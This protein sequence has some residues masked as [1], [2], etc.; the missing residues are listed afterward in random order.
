M[1]SQ[2][3]RKFRQ[4]VYLAQTLEVAKGITATGVLT[5]SSNV[6]VTGTLSVT[7][8]FTARAQANFQA[9]VDIDSVIQ[10]PMTIAITTAVSQYYGLV[11]GSTAFTV[12]VPVTDTAIQP[13]GILQNT[14]N[15]LAQVNMAIGGISSAISKGDG[16]EILVGDK[17]TLNALGQVIKAGTIEDCIGY[18]LQGS[19]T[20][21]LSIKIIV[22]PFNQGIA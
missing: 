7:G 1:A 15:Q 3:I 19:K 11:L 10:T 16:T 17:L 5:A 12:A 14:G 6:G 2:A 9:A 13:I 4:P 22:Q 18:A 21:A 20:D 8:I